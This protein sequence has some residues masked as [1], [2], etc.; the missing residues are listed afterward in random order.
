[1]DTETKQKAIMFIAERILVYERTRKSEAILNGDA[2]LKSIVSDLEIVQE[3][4]VGA[5]TDV[6][7]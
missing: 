7:H 6:E 2:L 1:M 5:R 3:F 4:L